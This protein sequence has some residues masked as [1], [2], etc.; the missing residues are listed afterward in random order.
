[1]RTGKKIKGRAPNGLANAWRQQVAANI[2]GGYVSPKT[3]WFDTDANRD[4]GS[5]MQQVKL[6]KV[7]RDNAGN[8]IT[9]R[10]AIRLLLERENP[11]IPGELLDK[12]VAS[13]PID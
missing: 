7:T 3:P 13:I 1:M 11:G 9:S 6:R 10:A 4:N 2:P 5:I 12:A 8:P